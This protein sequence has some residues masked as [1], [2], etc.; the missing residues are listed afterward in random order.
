MS[1]KT[2]ATAVL[3]GFELASHLF[4]EGLEILGTGDM[5]HRQHHPFRRHRHGSHR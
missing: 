4:D 1:R 2:A 5:G 3:T